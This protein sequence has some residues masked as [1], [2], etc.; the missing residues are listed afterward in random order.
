MFCGAC[1][2]HVVAVEDVVNVVYVVYVVD[3][4]AG[5]LYKP[6]LRLSEVF[7]GV[8][9]SCWMMLLDDAVG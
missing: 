8:E 7:D 1:G 2:Q 5:P 6:E 3:I 4:L 9:R